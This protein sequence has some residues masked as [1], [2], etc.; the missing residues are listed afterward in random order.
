MSWL[1]AVAVS[2]AIAGPVDIYG[3]GAQSIGRGQGGVAIPDG[4]MTVMRNPALLQDLGQAQASIGYGMFRSAFAEIPPLY[5]DTNRDGKID[6]TDD[7]L[8][9]QPGGSN[10][11]ALTLAIG[12]NVGQRF[13]LAFNGLVPS[14]HL[15]RL[16]TVEPA[17]P[18]W[19]MYGNRS[20]RYELALGFGYEVY[21]GI[22][23]GASV[24][25]IA[26]ARYRVNATL[27]AGV[28][29]AEEGDETVG[30]LV[31]EI[32]LDVHDMTLDL[33]PAFIP[34]VGVH[35]DAGKLFPVLDG[36]ALGAVYRGESG[37]P[38]EVDID[39]QVDANVSSLGEFDPILLSLALPIQVEIF[40]HYVPERWSWGLA[41]QYKDF[42]R[43]YVDVHHY[44][45]SRM[46]LNVARLTAS[47]LKSQLLQMGE[48]SISDGNS[49][50]VAFRNTTEVHTGLEGWL[51]KINT[52]GPSEFV[53]FV[54]RSGVGYAPSP[55]LRQGVG[56]NFLDSDRM[57][58]AGGLG[59]NHM[60]PFD[61][62]PGLV[63]WDLFFTYHQL[64]QGRLAQSDAGPH[65]P[66][67]PVGGRAIPIG[68][69]LWSAGVQWSV[70]F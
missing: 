31:D 30:D 52:K 41:Y 11:D 57:L 46:R 21:K 42:A 34:V 25:L 44:N 49:Y 5:W 60:D 53:Q 26:K 48:G 14:Q 9:A 59:V 24:E 66:G 69:H 36:L 15:L 33:V 64:A 63:A 70:D 50:A 1:L 6:E 55:L 39:I 22:S 3:F 17:M 68:G 27:R 10:A 8:Q 19:I 32:E 18:N 16:R 40:D 2:A 51:P 61:L 37:L 28:S 23:I 56:S 45:W 47:E 38:I 43:A 58:F 29:G 13:A 35:W 4:A 20:Q 67:S 62:V 12:R 54:L 7:P 65:R